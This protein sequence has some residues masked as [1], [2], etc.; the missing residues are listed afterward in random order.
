MSIWIL[1]AAITLGVVVVFSALI[2]KLDAWRRR[3]RWERN[4][5]RPGYI[6]EEVIREIRFFDQEVQ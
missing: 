6:T 5:P 2:L 4:H 1:Y 3:R